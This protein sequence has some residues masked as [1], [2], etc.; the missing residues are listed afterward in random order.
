M[1]QASP[2]W[3]QPTRQANSRR[4]SSGRRDWPVPDATCPAIPYRAR[5]MR[6][7][8]PH[9]ANPALLPCDYP[10]LSHTSHPEP[11]RLSVPIRALS[12]RRIVPAPAKPRQTIHA[13]GSLAK[14]MRLAG[15]TRPSPIPA[16]ATVRTKSMRPAPTRPFPYSKIT[17]GLTMAKNGDSIRNAMYGLAATRHRR[18]QPGPAVSH[19]FGWDIHG[20]NG[21]GLLSERVR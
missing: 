10:S 12:M 16:N 5:P 2:V 13:A 19:L 9:Q 20:A 11:A 21:P 8:C 6:L 18:F 1:R 4:T 15:P 7:D 17:G 3:A 14:P